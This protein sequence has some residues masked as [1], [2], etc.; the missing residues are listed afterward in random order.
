M[1]FGELGIGLA[2]GVVIA[3]AMLMFLRIMDGPLRRPAPPRGVLAERVR[4]RVIVTMSDGAA[5]DGVLYDAD[6]DAL[7]LRAATAVGFGPQSENVIV[8]GEVLLLRAQIA[9]TQIP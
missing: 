4:R 6:A 5:F 7:V 1:T 9:Y 8:E 2:V 3:V